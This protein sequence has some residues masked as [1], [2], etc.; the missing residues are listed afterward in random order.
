MLLKN[1]VCLS[2]YAAA[3]TG[4]STLHKAVHEDKKF[5]AEKTS[6][7]TSRAD[8]RQQHHR[9]FLPFSLYLFLQCCQ[10]AKRVNMSVCLSN[11]CFG[12]LADNQ[13]AAR[14]TS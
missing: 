5:G 12:M 8:W 11:D 14:Y 4:T 10:L 1:S 3:R 7:K 9:D 13:F 6:A 2:L